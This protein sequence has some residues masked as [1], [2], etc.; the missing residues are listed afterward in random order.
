MPVV[1]HDATGT[2][3]I[4]QLPHRSVL[5]FVELFLFVDTLVGVRVAIRFE[6][7]F[8]IIF[9]FYFIGI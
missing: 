4:K 3:K 7:T 8:I 6:L 1:F 9:L 2:Y 5:W